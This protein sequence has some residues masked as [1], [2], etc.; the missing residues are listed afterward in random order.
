L[1]DRIGIINEGKIV[2]EGTLDELREIAQAAGA[3]LEDVFLKIT[4]EDEDIRE[5]LVKLKETLK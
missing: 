5:I 4:E 1:C 3:S 2:A